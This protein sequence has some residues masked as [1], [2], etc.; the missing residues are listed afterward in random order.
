M[1]REQKL[2]WER[3]WALPAAA[4]AIAAGLALLLQIVL[5]QTAVDDRAGIESLPDYYLSIDANNGQFLA[6]TGVQVL[7]ALALIVVFLYLYRAITHREQA[8]PRWFVYFVFL[9]PAL[10]AASA[11]LGGLDTVDKASDFVDRDVLR[12]DRGADAAEAIQDETNGLT[13]GLAYAGTIGVAFLFVMLPLRSRRVGLL[14]PFMGILGVVCGALLVLPLLPPI[15]SV[16]W[17]VAL[18]LLFLDRW[19]GGRGPAWASGESDPWLSAAQRRALEEKGADDTR[20]D[21]DPSGN[22][23]GDPREAEA[24]TRPSSRKRRRPS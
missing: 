23:S 15:I 22:G 6:A 9:G 2:D 20:P 18:G 1:T 8:M 19:P 7:G 17:L 10:Y 4:A 24:P 12:G 3:R 16:F 14:S 11:L 13:L 21:G 5:V